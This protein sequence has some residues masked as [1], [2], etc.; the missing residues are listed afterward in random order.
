MPQLAFPEWPSDS[1]RNVSSFHGTLLWPL[2]THRELSPVL[3]PGRTRASFQSDTNSAA[4]PLAFLQQGQLPA[5]ERSTLPRGF[6]GTSF[7]SCSNPSPPRSNPKKK[8]RDSGYL[9]TQ[10][11]QD[12]CHSLGRASILSRGAILPHLQIKL[13][14]RPS[15]VTVASCSWCLK[16]LFCKTHSPKEKCP[17]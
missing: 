8:P 16:W 15:A 17:L 12:N 13:T 7:M 1:Y 14:S 4:S 5:L 9:Q 2:L 3:A 6:Q 11:G 10:V